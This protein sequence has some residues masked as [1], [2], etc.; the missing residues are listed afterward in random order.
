MNLASHVKSSVSNAFKPRS[1]LQDQNTWNLYGDIAWYG[2]L[3]GVTTSF[4][5]VLVLR[6]GGSDTHVGLL[7]SLPALI[8][9]F[10]AVPGSRLIERE[11]KALRILNIT[12]FLSRTG[13]FAIAL[14][15]FFL[16]T[17]RADV[18]ILIVALLT[19]PGAIANVAFSTMFGFLVEPKNRARVVS[20]RNVWIGI[21]STLAAFLGGI[22]LDLVPFPINYQVL[23]IIAFA[24]SLVSQSYLMRIRMP[25]GVTSDL[26]RVH[27]EGSAVNRVVSMF[28][29][30][31]KFT[32][33]TLSSFV[34]HWGLFFPIQSIGFAI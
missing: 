25:P 7:S 1:S 10:S 2:V 15:P 3:S 28:Q 11:P 4:L 19:I 13:Y 17:N 34:F 18:I 14:V 5:S 6:V 8:T 9:I 33:F 24:A 23:F 21:T 29:N 31:H 30:S 20:I 22:F 26:A 32:R 12:A 27:D 16:T